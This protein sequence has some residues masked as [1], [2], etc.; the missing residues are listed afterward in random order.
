[1]V[2]PLITFSSSQEREEV[3]EV[4]EE[5]IKMLEEKEK[6]ADNMTVRQELNIKIYNEALE[7]IKQSLQEAI[8]NTKHGD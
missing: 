8:D 1:M 2:F 7:D 5:V 3:L 4:L 6:W